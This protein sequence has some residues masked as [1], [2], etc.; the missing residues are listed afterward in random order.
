MKELLGVSG[1]VKSWDGVSGIPSERYR[2]CIT[3]SPPAI[4][5]T[6]RQDNAVESWSQFVESG[7]SMFQWIKDVFR[8]LEVV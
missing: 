8:R 5:E 7:P 4:L 6:D 2:K 3:Y 1:Y